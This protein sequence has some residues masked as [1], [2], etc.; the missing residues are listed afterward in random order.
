MPLVLPLWHQP[1]GQKWLIW[2]ISGCLH[3]ERVMGN[4]TA[5]GLL[6]LPMPGALCKPEP[7]PRK[8]QVISLWRSP[9]A[10]GFS[11]SFPFLS[12]P[13]LFSERCIL[14]LLHHPNPKH[15]WGSH[16]IK[17]L[18]T[19]AGSWVKGQQCPGGRG[20]CKEELELELLLQPPPPLT[21][22]L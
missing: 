13:L 19:P 10:V 17:S 2:L 16:S 22:P 4:A 9:K 12:P 11:F 20:V 8:S 7:R 5:A 15:I 18:L 21:S 3:R 14:L 1:G 6:A